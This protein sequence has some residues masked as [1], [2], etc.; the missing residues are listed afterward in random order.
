[1][2]SITNFHVSDI[3]VTDPNLLN[4]L[5]LSITEHILDHY[6]EFAKDGPFM[7]IFDHL[8]KQEV[9]NLKSTNIETRLNYSGL[10]F[11]KTLDQFYFHFQ[12]S[13][14]RKIT[15]NLM[16]LRF[17]HNIE[18]VVFL[19]PSVVEKAHLEH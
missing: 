11:S 15:N 5:C 19:S 7:E 6:L 17:L 16:T 12:S 8:L 3:F 14:G 1:M 10:S 9:K 2:A 18:Y 4:R 13:I